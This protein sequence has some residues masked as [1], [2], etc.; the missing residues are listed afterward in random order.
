MGKRVVL[1][2]SLVSHLLTSHTTD[3]PTCIGLTDDLA[4]F[5]LPT[6]PYH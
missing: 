2:F 3:V 1:R 6:K 5:K 4:P